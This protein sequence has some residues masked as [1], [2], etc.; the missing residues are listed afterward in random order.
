MKTSKTQLSI[1]NE[2][3][4]EKK[5]QEALNIYYELSEKEKIFNNI[6]EVNIKITEKRI[7]RNSKEIIHKKKLTEFDPEWYCKKYGDVASAKIDPYLHFKVSGK[8]EGRFPNEYSEAESRLD[9]YWY[10]QKY[11]G[12]KKLTKME[13]LEHYVQK[14]KNLEFSANE[15]ELIN[16][17]PFRRFGKT[18]YGGSFKN[19]YHYDKETKLINSNIKIAVHLHLFY[20]EMLDEFCE[21]LN[22]ITIKFGLYISIPESKSEDFEIVTKKAQALVPHADIKISITE[23]QGRDIAPMCIHFAKDLLNYDL[24]LH[25]HSKKTTHNP[26]HEGWRS[27]LLHHVLGNKNIVNQILNEFESDKKLGVVF[28]P[29]FHS[30]RNQPSW[31]E[32]KK[33]AN[34]LIERLNLSI[35]LPDECPDYPAGS[36]FWSRTKSIKP[37]L[38]S[39]LELKDFDKEKGQV[40]KTTAHGIERL[41]GILPKALGYKSLIRY[42]DIAYNLKNYFPADRTYKNS[43]SPK[44][45]N[46]NI[47]KYKEKRKKLNKSNIA[48]I[49]AITGG[50][51][52]LTYPETL[53]PEIDYI[54]YTDTPAPESSLYQNRIIDYKNDDPRRVARYVKTNLTNLVEN[55]RFLIWVDANVL[56]KADPKIFV[57]ILAKNNADIGGILHPIRSSFMEEANEILSLKL[58]DSEKIKTQMKRYLAEKSKKKETPLIETNFM[59]FDTNSNQVKEFFKTWWNE[60]KNFSK[61]DQLSVNFALEKSE[62]KFISLLPDKKSTRDSQ[63][64]SLFSHKKKQILIHL[65]KDI[66]KVKSIKSL[67]NN[68]SDCQYI[69]PDYNVYQTHAPQSIAPPEEPNKS[70][71]STQHLPNG[72]SLTNWVPQLW[73]SCTSKPTISITKHH[74]CIVYGGLINK[75]TPGYHYNGQTFISSDFHI[76][77]SSKGVWNGEK[78]LPGDILRNLKTNTW[79]LIREPKG[80]DL[81]GEFVLLGNIQPH[82]GHAILEALSRLWFLDTELAENDKIKYL[83]YEP[84]LRSYHNELFSLLKIDNEKIIYASRLGNRVE[85]LYVPDPGMRTHHWISNLQVNTWEKIA[86][87]IDSSPPS[88]KVYLSRRKIKERPLEN[89]SQV[90]KILSESGFEIFHPQD[91]SLKEQIR[92][93]KE[94]KV[95]AGP[96]GSQLYLS[97]FQQ[98]GTKKIIFAPSNFYAKDDQLMSIAKRQ[99]CIVAFGTK[100]DNLASRDSRNWRINE[101]DIIDCIKNI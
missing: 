59:V 45:L 69:I 96:V 58:D 94:A 43:K 75:T 39:E 98:E 93:A 46:E 33:I 28:P 47:E 35:T 89:E 73:K 85:K 7:G 41:L 2:L 52:N 42:I 56:V 86:K 57:D 5:Y 101:K 1:A 12:D 15:N 20:I 36:F 9:T 31:G 63:Y 27:Y 17:N 64:F 10:C 53:N 80:K 61:R 49:T 18:E 88:R 11:L 68:E 81:D 71:I 62:A 4:R 16:K 54:L 22:N 72:V 6:L 100:I 84:D 79:E 21:Y 29:Y 3:F 50:F 65:K 78:T 30:L 13:I 38:S 37:L 19:N 32:N 25:M 92:M 74:N 87:N 97:A 55:Y 26:N 60:V 8:K 82:F 14:G 90:E 40:D 67:V 44:T 99:H 51:E 23:N 66:H 70:D 91:H 76:T 48:V 83:V 77:E 34:N 24:V 95:L